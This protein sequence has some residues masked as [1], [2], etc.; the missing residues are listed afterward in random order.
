MALFLLNLSINL[1]LVGFIYTFSGLFS[2]SFIFQF[3]SFA[4][5]LELSLK[6]RTGKGQ[7]FSKCLFGVFK[8]CH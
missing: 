4:S 6:N 3:E 5:R 8:S 2:S 7:L 1:A